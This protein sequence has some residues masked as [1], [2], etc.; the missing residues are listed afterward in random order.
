MND[1]GPE[2][3]ENRSPDPA[4][5]KAPLP[6]DRDE[7]ASPPIENAQHRANRRTGEQALRTWKPASKTRNGSA[8]RTTFR[9][10]IATRAT[11]ASFVP[12]AGV[13]S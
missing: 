1:T 12:A 3:D 8:R 9:R 4:G 10:R 5:D 6:H 7:H 2:P 13:G 11:A